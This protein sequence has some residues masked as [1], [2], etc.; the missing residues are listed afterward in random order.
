L[1]ESQHRRTRLSLISGG[2]NSIQQG[3]AKA[4][5][6]ELRASTPGWAADPIEGHNRRRVGMLA[7]TKCGNKQC[8]FLLMNEP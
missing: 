1:I 3:H 6:E 7:L 5:L 8:R 4:K 2:P